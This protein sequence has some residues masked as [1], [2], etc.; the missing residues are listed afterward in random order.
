MRL[1]EMGY[2]P[3]LCPAISLR[4]LPET[5]LPAQDGLAGLI[6]TS[7]NGVLY[8]CQRSKDRSLPAWCVGPATAQAAREA[9]FG[10]VRN[11]MGDADRLAA[12]IETKASPE[13]GQLLHVA[14]SAAGGQLAD[15][16]RQAGF[17][18]G[19]APLYAPSP[20]PVLTTEAAEALERG[21]VCAVLFHSAKGA[22]AF[23]DLV[24]ATGFDLRAAHAVGVSQ[25]ALGPV[26]DLDW[27]GLTAPGE[28]NES[29][30]LAALQHVLTPA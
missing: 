17:K 28:P 11:A 4:T 13:D 9:G 19:F 8:F 22:E 25:K 7:A 21:E 24:S 30:L 29:A 3:I 15:R 14:N 5:P 16:L 6:F 12:F 18:V 10:D 2:E 27:A 26:A 1:E 23:A 20:A